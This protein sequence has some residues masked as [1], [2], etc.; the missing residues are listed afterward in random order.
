MSPMSP[1]RREG[2]LGRPKM[3]GAAPPTFQPDA[4]DGVGLPSLAD[5]RERGWDP[6][7]GGASTAA[8]RAEPPHDGPRGRRQDAVVISW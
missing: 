8:T 2:H 6:S 1:R 4:S 7:A 5:G 3:L